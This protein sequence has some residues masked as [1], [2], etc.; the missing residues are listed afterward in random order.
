MPEYIQNAL[1]KYNHI[2][3]SKKQYAP[4]VWAAKTYGKGQQSATPHDETPKLK[5]KHITVVQ[6]KIGTFLYYGRAV[7]PTILPALGEIALKQANPT[8]QTENEL[9]MLMDYLCT[10]T[11]AKL[12]YYAGT[13]QLH[14][15]SDAAYLILPGAKS[16]I[17]GHYVL[18]NNTSTK[19]S[20]PIFT[21]CK[22]I[23]HVICSAAE[24]ETHGLFIN[25]QNAI[26]IRN[27][28]EGLGHIQGKTT[29]ITDNT[30]AEGF[31]NKTMKEKRSKTWDMRYN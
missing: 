4:H 30:T 12:R 20:S 1:K 18:S 14:V 5:G 16:R 17:A 10:Y 27:A 7:D 13:M 26:I 6:S 28:L 22:A 2:I 9:N 3:P 31:A 19:S 25:C 15:E 24:A 23:R 8:K 11:N 21:E 29:V